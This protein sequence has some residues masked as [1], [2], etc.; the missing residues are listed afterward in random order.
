M[1]PQ[2]PQQVKKAICI[3][4]LTVCSKTYG[5]PSGRYFVPL[6]I[7]SLS[8]KWLQDTG[9]K[10]GHIVDIVCEAGKLT[11]TLANEQRYID[12]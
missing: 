12:K 9:F 1:Q 11:I 2:T 4:R 5:R 8:G 10:I 6:P 7:L 3:R